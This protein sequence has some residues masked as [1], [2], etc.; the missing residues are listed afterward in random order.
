MRDVA[1]AVALVSLALAG[2]LGVP[3]PGAPAEDA[4]SDASEAATGNATTV[5]SPAQQLH[6]HDLWRGRDNI[7]LFD[8]SVQVNATT[9][10]TTGSEPL[11]GNVGPNTCSGSDLGIGA[12]CLGRVTFKPPRSADASQ[13]K[14][15]APGTWALRATASWSDQT[16]TG[17]AFEAD[18]ANGD[19]LYL[20]DVETSGGS[21]KVN[22]TRF[23]ENR[24]YL[25]LVVSDD[26]HATV[27]QW[28]FTLT[29]SGDFGSFLAV[30]DGSVDVTVEAIRMDGDLPEEPP[31]P[32]WYGDTETYHVGFEETVARNAYRV[33][34]MGTDW[35]SIHMEPENP[36]PPGTN[37][38]LA[39]VNITNDSPTKDGPAEPEV[40]AYYSTDGNYWGE[41]HE[42]EPEIEEDGRRLYR[43]PVDGRMTDSLYTCQGRNSTWSFDVYVQPQSLAGEPVL[44]TDVRG[45][46]HFSGRV[47]LTVTATEKT[48]AEPAD[49][50]P[51]NP[52]AVDG[53]GAVH[54]YGDDDYYYD[55]DD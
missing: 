7:T 48:G 17:V 1:I 31:H 54:D 30:A 13:P 19:D 45:A 26:G 6:V 51:A 24:T 25:P 15:V 46:M 3:A 44:G 38:V 18:A 33:T 16:I 49:L 43:I 40:A 39:E 55:P 42:L 34:Y 8:D 53:C 52:K 4:T 41:Q 32:D 37:E 27:S 22:A 28:S 5:A 29:A 14:V 35:V 10:D 23:G 20:G 2:C 9:T 12:W 21:V 50:V 11:A 36:I 47:G